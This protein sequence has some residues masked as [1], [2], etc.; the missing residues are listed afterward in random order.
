[1]IKTPAKPITIAIH[2]LTLTSS[3]SIN[4]D[5]SVLKI[6][7]ANVRLTVVARGN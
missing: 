7:D 1:M 5:S 6:G 2:L 4:I 3:P